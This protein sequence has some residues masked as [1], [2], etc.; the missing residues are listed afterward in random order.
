M[1]QTKSFSE[2]T[3][4]PTASSG[5]TYNDGRVE[6]DSDAT[7]RESRTS[8]MLQN[9]AVALTD[10]FLAQ[11]GEYD[12]NK[13]PPNADVPFY[14]V[15]FTRKGSDYQFSYFAQPHIHKQFM[16][17]I[18]ARHGL[19]RDTMEL[20]SEYVG[21]EIS[22]P[23]YIAQMA[24]AICGCEYGTDPFKE[25]ISRISDYDFFWIDKRELARWKAKVGR[26]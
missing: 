5:S 22:M 14:K 21:H 13:F 2:L 11:D 1:Q 23:P 12:L 3:K 19:Y 18:E 6:I 26:S 7:D 16:E 17:E 4:T 9:M 20:T 25:Y 8:A 15:T 10:P 24:E